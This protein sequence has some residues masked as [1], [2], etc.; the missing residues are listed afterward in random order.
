MEPH[1]EQIWKSK[2]L[3]AA[4]NDMDMDRNVPLAPNLNVNMN[5]KMN[6]S[7]NGDEFGLTSSRFDGVVIGSNGDVNF[8]PILEKIFR[9]LTSD[10]KEER[11]LASISLFDLLVSLEHELS[12][13]EFQA[14]SNDINNK[15][16]ELVHTKKT[17][18]RVGAV[19]SI[20][21]LISFYAY[22]ERLPNETSRLAGYLRGLIPSNDVEVM[23]LAAK[24]LGKLAV[25]G[26][27]YT[28]DFVEFE[29]KS[30]L[31]WLT[32]STEKNSF[33]S[34]KPDHAKHAAL[35]IIT[36]LAENCP[37][38]LYQYLNSILDNIWRALRDPHL[39]I[40]IDA[41]ITLAKCLSTLRNRDPQ[42]TSQWVQRL[43]TSCEYG[44]QVNTLECIHASLLVYKE[45]LFLKDPFLNQVFDQMCLN[46][47][48]YENHKAKMIREKIYQIVPLLASFNPQ[49]FAGKYLHQIMD[50]YLEILTNA[51]AKKIPHLK[52]DKPQILISIGDIAYEVG[53]DIA[54][55]VKQILDYIEHDLQTKFKFR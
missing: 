25:P 35:L 1:E 24:T 43:A 49:L 55:Y 32:A 53:P 46:C 44:F 42:L 7:R 45:I 26:G 21:T 15:I 18:T 17:S 6:A 8:K 51:P 13:E 5:M 12:I 39:V 48:A 23:R 47:I 33:S 29:I 41:S 40:R 30:C 14:V 4:N 27:T 34:S 54:P 37:Y 36:A 31:E 11:K 20:D 38:L 16:L 28:S 10:Y 22:T 2:L 9:E 19:L 3:K 50:K 52:D